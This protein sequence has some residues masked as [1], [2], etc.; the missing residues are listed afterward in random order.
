MKRKVSFWPGMIM[1]LLS[2]LLNSSVVI[3]QRTIRG[4]VTDAADGLPLPAVSV[5]VRGGHG[6]YL[7]TGRRHLYS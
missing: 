6:R 2:L 7:N 3:A 5:V 1:M 4:T